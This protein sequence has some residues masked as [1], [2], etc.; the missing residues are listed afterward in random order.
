MVQ[1]ADLFAYLYDVHL[2]TLRRAAGETF[3]ILGNLKIRISRGGRTRG[4][5]P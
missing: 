1:L 2:E 5:I 4:R 3:R